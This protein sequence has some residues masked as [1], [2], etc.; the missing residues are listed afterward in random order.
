MFWLNWKGNLL[1]YIDLSHIHPL[2]HSCVATIK[3]MKGNSGPALQSLPSVLENF[4]AGGIIMKMIE[5]DDVRF[6]NE[7][8]IKYCDALITK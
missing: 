5:N 4:A 1:F 3:G 8:Q 7:I 6:L 2:V